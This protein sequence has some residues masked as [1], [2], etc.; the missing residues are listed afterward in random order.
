MPNYAVSTAFT[1]KD[2]VSAAF[3]KMGRNATKFGDKTTRAFNRASRGGTQFNSVMKGVLAAG[4]VQRALGGVSRGIGEVTNQFISFDDAVIGAAVRFKDIGPDAANFTERLNAI[5]F[6]AR[7]VG[8]TTRFT[9]TQAAEGLDFMARAGLNSV[10]AMGSL[11]SMIE[12]ATA[13]GEDFAMVTDFSTDLLGAFGLG[14]GSAEQKIRDITRVNDVLTKTANSA[15]VTVETMF[16]TMKLAGPIARKVGMSIEEVAAATGLLGSAGIKGT[17]AG[18]ALKN[19]ILN[20][21]STKVQKML[22]ANGVA[23]TNAEGDML[24]YSQIL[25]NIGEK[26]SALGNVKQAQILTDI[27]GKRAIAATANLMDMVDAFDIFTEQINAAGGVTERTSKILE[28]SLGNRLLALKSAATELGFKILDAFDK[29]GRK[30]IEGLTMALREFDVKPIVDGIKF[31]VG[32]FK[33]LWTIIQPFLPALPWI[34][35]GFIALKTTVAA[36]TIG[37]AV[38]SWIKFFF[39]LKEVVGVVGIF[40][41]LLQLNPIGF[42][43][44]GIVAAVAGLVWLEKKFGFVTKSIELMKTAFFGIVTFLKTVFINTFASVFTTILGWIARVGKFAGLDVTGIEAMMSKSEKFRQ[45]FNANLEAP[46]AKEA[47]ARRSQFNG[48]LTIAGAP[49]GS[50]VESTS[51]GVDGF[52]VELLGVAP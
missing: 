29:D 21:T 11:R 23:V 45:D 41:G 1:A 17:L 20:L 50:T 48:R 13:T 38:A 8:Q 52:D 24:K 27:F 5:K 39:I 36:F 3:G 44:T 12:L 47:E 9:A 6:A 35:G 16:E 32:V 19:S 15:N 28:K 43:I 18:T 7:E 37:A 2:K 14:L 33:Q 26:L 46:N 10:V 42:L 30:G 22:K 31:T 40:T 51:S 34:I 4:A 25:G 49:E